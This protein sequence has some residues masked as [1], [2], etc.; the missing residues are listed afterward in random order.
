MFS[1]ICGRLDECA[2]EHGVLTLPVYGSHVN[3]ASFVH[4]RS[5]SAFMYT[6]ASL[7]TEL[8]LCYL[9]VPVN[10]QGVS[11]ACASSLLPER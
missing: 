11:N 1:T 8:R 5:E 2:R 3:P 7:Y 4:S 9:V 10:H 6:S